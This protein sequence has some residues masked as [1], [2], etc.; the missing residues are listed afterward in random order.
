LLEDLLSGIAQGS[1]YGL[2]AMGMSIM[3]YVTRVIN[4]AQ[5]QVAMVAVMVTAEAVASGWPI[6]V[7][8]LVAVIVTI[9]VGV[10]TYVV[11]VRPV[12]VFDRFSFSWLASTLGVALI[13]EN[14]AATI[15][16][17]NTEPFP[18]LL[19]NDTVRLASATL[20][21]QQIVT[22]CAALVLAAAF[23]LVRRRTLL[24]K[25]GMAV[26]YDPEMASTFGAST[27][28]FS[29]AAFAIAAFLAAVA[30]VLVG[31]IVFATPFLGSTYGIDGFIAL[32]LAGL[33]RPA[34][35]IFGGMILGVLNSGAN[36]FINP[37]AS[38]WFPFVVVVL[39]LLFI[40]EGLF[41][42]SIANS[43]FAVGLRRSLGILKGEQ[44]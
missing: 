19:N 18:A 27:F 29:V 42:G 9:V 30:G 44:A 22:V 40:P 13:L 12:L 24:G 16:G 32:M 14:T 25:A 28:L 38:T 15:W 8:I 41:S 20:T 1:V 39:V 43:R 11:A 37:Q 10:I 36:A 4:F 6:A 2:I 33:K 3:W 7:A 17:T 23:E 35:A 5:G 31:P 26:A 21:V 34:T